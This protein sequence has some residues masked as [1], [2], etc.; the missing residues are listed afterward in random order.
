MPS[1]E[2]SLAAVIQPLEGG[3]LLAEALLFPEASCA[4][5]EIEVL[6]GKL[7]DHAQRIMREEATEE[8]YRRFLSATPEAGTITLSLKPPKH[9]SAWQQPVEL[10]FP[11]LRWAHPAVNNVAGTASPAAGHPDLLEV[12]EA[13]RALVPALGIEVIARRADELDRVLEA[14]IRAALLRTRATGSLE[15]LVWL[16]RCSQVRLSVRMWT[17]NLTSPKQRA[18]AEAE[19]RERADSVLPEVGIDL[20]AVTLTPAYAVDELVGRLAEHLTGRSPRSVLLVGPSGVGKTAIVHELVRRRDTLGLGVTPFWATSGARLVAG[21]SGFGMWQERCQ[22]L[23]REASRKRAILHLGGLMELVDVGKSEHQSQGIASF[24][25]RYLA[26]GDLLAIAECT[27]EQ[28]ALV[29]RQEPGLLNAFARLDVEEPGPARGRS[30]LESVALASRTHGELPI[31]PEALDKVDRLHRRY[32]TY[33]AYPG[34][35]LRFLQ[36]MLADLP[37]DKTVTMAAVTAAFARE[38]GLPHFLLDADVPLDLTQARTWFAGRVIGQ[39]EAVDLVV[40]LL[41]TI[42][43]ELARP[44]RPLAS[45]LFIGPTGVGKTEMAKSLAEFLFGS[46]QR[47]T[48]FDMSEYADSLAVERLIGGG[49]QAEGLLTARVREQPFS[50]VLLDEVEKAD[51]RFFDLLLQV[52]GDGRLTDSHGRLADFCNSVV[53]MT[54]NLGADT[55][56]QGGFGVVHT[57]DSRA[58]ARDHFT[59]AVEAFVR[60]ELFNRIDRIVPFAP[61]DEETILGVARRQLDLV[62][63][64]DGIRYRGV[65]LDVDADVALWLAQRGYDAR[66]GAR[67]LKRAM[68]R[69]LLARLAD[70]LNGYSGETPLRAVVGIHGD[71]LHI[72]VRARADDEGIPLAARED[73]DRLAE[74]DDQKSPSEI[75]TSGLQL[76]RDMQRLQR[77][78]AGL[79]MHNEIARLEQ[80]E[81]S[82]RR[83]WTSAEDFL[84][85]ERLSMWRR[86]RDRFDALLHEVCALEDASVLALHGHGTFEVAQTDAKLDQI[87]R[88]WEDRLVE[89]YL[90]REGQSHHQ[91]TLAIFS[92]KPALLV[93]LTAAYYQ[94][95]VSR[96]A[97]ARLWQFLPG[98]PARDGKRVPARRLVA[99]ADR[100]FRQTGRI[101]VRRWD[102][103]T[104][105]LGEPESV[106]PLAGVVGCALEIVGPAVQLRFGSESGLHVFE[107]PGMAGRCLVDTGRGRI[108]DYE[109]PVGIERRGAIT[110]IYSKRRIYR[111]ERSEAED[112]TLRQIV[113]ASDLRE[114]IAEAT[115]GILRRR[116]R[117][118]LDS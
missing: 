104:S 30:I 48:R 3:C 87:R 25:R 18:Q 29:E 56:Q 60:P 78:A 4:G 101:S 75:V 52:L 114:A 51:A 59:R 27:P 13:V 53:I 45:L 62:R 106:D 66:Y 58:H 110:N 24:L 2:V 34:R 72:K 54:S 92:E 21:M 19:A 42:K 93:I 55:Y 73:V 47:L 79:E 74:Q 115:E 76:R 113:R 10:T 98:A 116:I 43:A 86:L 22:R 63:Q 84:E 77:S 91:L 23:W 108:G 11:V 100:F 97:R 61:L 90:V 14:H 41:A 118:M 40:D 7:A 107:D 112:L 65:A 96:G 85:L 33:S 99:D 1:H 6:Q 81:K 44:R 69:E 95:L 38:T 64:R 80:I 12:P 57:A 89:L 71:A 50:V 103:Q 20:S 68:E 46:A 39:T 32:A 37:H 8:L 70:H 83:G 109:P 67:P 88:E 111:L 105:K 5:D 17:V 49:C 102:A 94:V 26:R 28:V 31:D 117:E 16:Q 9:G 35:P 15:Q 36:G 82:R